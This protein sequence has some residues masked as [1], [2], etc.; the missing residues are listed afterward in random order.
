MR[1]Q[2]FR[3]S[4]TVAVVPDVLEVP[5][6][7]R[8]QREQ[9]TTLWVDAQIAHRV[10]Q[11]F[12]YKDDTLFVLGIAALGFGALYILIR[13]LSKDERGKREDRGDE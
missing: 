5:A 9:D 7:D 13:L 1:W 8:L 6:R 11:Q 3:C 2:R 4:R 10:Y 12:A